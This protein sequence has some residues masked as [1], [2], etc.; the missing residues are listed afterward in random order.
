[1][2]GDQARDGSEGLSETVADLFVLGVAQVVQIKVDDQNVHGGIVGI[3][4][5]TSQKKR[6]KAGI[7]GQISALT[8]FWGFA[9]RPRF[10]PAAGQGHELPR[11]PKRSCQHLGRLG[12]GRGRWPPP[13]DLV[14]RLCQRWGTCGTLGVCARTPWQLLLALLN[15][16]GPHRPWTG[17]WGRAILTARERSSSSSR[18]LASRTFRADRLVRHGSTRSDAGLLPN[19]RN[20]EAET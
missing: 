10:C 7:G 18:G 4:G 15:G 19:L 5:I 11:A 8:W 14:H 20:R 13:T 9:H 17:C 3:S 12:A 1:M 16:P 6:F 2:L